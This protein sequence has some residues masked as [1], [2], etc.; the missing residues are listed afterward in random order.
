MNRTVINF[1]PDTIR[2]FGAYWSWTLKDNILTVWDDRESVGFV[3]AKFPIDQLSDQIEHLDLL[4]PE[5]PL[6]LI[7]ELL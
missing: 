4:S 2:S 1:W 7:R 6:E 3:Y 5:L